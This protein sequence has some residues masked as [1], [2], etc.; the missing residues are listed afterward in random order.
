M[1]N[2]TLIIQLY[3]KKTATYININNK[4]LIAEYLYIFLLYRECDAPHKKE[5]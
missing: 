4:I 2:T 5:P 3:I 1:F